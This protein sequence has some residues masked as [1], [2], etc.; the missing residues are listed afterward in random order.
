M[1]V[2]FTLIAFILAGIVN[3]A[4]AQAP[5]RI[6]DIVGII[7]RT[8]TILSSIAA[9]AFLAMMLMAAFRYIKSAGDPKKVANAR[10]TLKYAA[11]GVILVAAAWLIL[12]VIKA[13]TGYNVTQVEF[14]S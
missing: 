8:I 12:L 11:F 1:V 7:E 3:P 13:V 6:S 9:I 10:D 5:A 2:V 4:Y 14:P